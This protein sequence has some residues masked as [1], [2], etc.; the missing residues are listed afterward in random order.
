MPRPGLQ[1]L[2][3]ARSARDTL[4]SRRAQMVAD[5][6]PFALDAHQ[7][8]GSSRRTTLRIDLQLRRFAHARSMERALPSHLKRDRFE[9]RRHALSPRHLGTRVAGRA[10]RRSCRDAAAEYLTACDPSHTSGY[11]LPHLARVSPPTRTATRREL[12]ARARYR[13]RRPEM[14]SHSSSSFPARRSALAEPTAD[15]RRYGHSPD[16]LRCTRRREAARRGDFIASDH[17]NVAV[18]PAEPFG[19]SRA[20]LDRSR[21]RSIAEGHSGLPSHGCQSGRAARSALR[22]HHRARLAYLVEAV[23]TLGL[24]S[25]HGRDPV[26]FPPRAR[27]RARFAVGESLAHV[28]PSS[29]RTFERR[30]DAE[31][32]VRSPPAA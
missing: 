22:E 29:R 20:L 14:H 10:L 1:F 26:R 23:A 15:H 30:I 5:A 6:A 24:R 12:E 2:F 25:C 31:G 19:A 3:S 32:N 21:I 11:S 9:D 13:A 28:N 7:P 18:W 27:P 4:E 8:C 17:T 16:T